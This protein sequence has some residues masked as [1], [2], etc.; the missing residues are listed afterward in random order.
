MT[1][2]RSWTPYCGA[3]PAPAEW[4]MRWNLDP[5]LLAALALAAFAFI[6]FGPA[7]RRARICFWSAW[8]LTV[9][10]FVSPL[11]AL[12]SALFSVRVVHHALLATVIAPLL[13]RAMPELPLSGGPLRWTAAH[14]L[15]LWFWHA[16]PAYDWALSSDGIFWAMQLSILAT[17]TGFWAAVRRAP[18]P[19][20][21]AV[22]LFSMAAMGLLGALITFA[23]VPLYAPHLLSAALWGWQPLEDQQLA[24][25]VMWVPASLLYL[26]AALWRLSPLLE[27]TAP[28][29]AR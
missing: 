3:A 6:R 14:V 21:L 5:L 16:P 18:A 11:C 2:A 15:T 17:A 10:L 22:L 29:R 8:G 13:A 1:D 23:P 25:L 4:A 27:P 24:G 28:A 12:S 19:A 7:E 9:L 26:A 20:A